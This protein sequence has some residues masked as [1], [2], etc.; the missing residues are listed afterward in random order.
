MKKVIIKNNYRRRILARKGQYVIIFSC[1]YCNNLSRDRESHFKKKKRHFCGKECYS[2]FRMFCLSKEEQ[3]AFGSGRSVEER[4]IRIKARSDL[5]HAVQQGKIRK[6]KACGIYR[7]R[8]VPEAHHDDY[9][10]P[11]EVRWLCFKHHR[12]H[13]KQ[14]PELFKELGE[15]KK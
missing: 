14:N 3:N 12:A 11:L 4:K 10:K 1:D 15:G 8:E 2:K 5:N 6:P 7:C 9:S 13:H